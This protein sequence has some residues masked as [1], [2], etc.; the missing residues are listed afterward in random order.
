MY[1]ILVLKLSDGI[2]PSILKSG[3]DGGERSASLSARFTLGELAAAI[4]RIGGWVGPKA[5]LDAVKKRK[6]LAS[7]RNWLRISLPSSQ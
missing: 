7:A 6:S 2:A 1:V 4:H 3:Q 5:G